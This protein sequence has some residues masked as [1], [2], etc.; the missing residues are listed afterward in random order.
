M[1]VPVSFFTADELNSAKGIFEESEF[2][3]KTVGTGNVCERAAALTGDEIIIKKTV[4][5]SVTVAV[6]VSKWEA[7]F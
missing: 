1:N 7:V 4:E 6:S 5:N 2:V 3:R